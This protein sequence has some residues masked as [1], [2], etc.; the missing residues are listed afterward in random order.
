MEEFPYKNGNVRQVKCFE[1]HTM[2]PGGKPQ[3]KKVKITLVPSSSSSSH[4]LSSKYCLICLLN[5][6]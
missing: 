2:D 1:D 3:A 4:N 5:I 6:S